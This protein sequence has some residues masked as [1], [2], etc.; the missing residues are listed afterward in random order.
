[1]GENAA[2]NK[3]QSMA[4]K[5]QGIFCSTRLERKKVL[6]IP[7]RR[8][9]GIMDTL[10]IEPRALHE[11]DVIP[12][13]HVPY[14]NASNCMLFRWALRAHSTQG[15]A[16]KDHGDFLMGAA[17]P[18]NAG[19][20]GCIVAMDRPEPCS[21]E[22]WRLLRACSFEKRVRAHWL[23]SPAVAETCARYDAIASPNGPTRA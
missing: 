2:A 8:A 17:S 23:P 4:G 12:L 7:C 9:P 10:G 11:A 14:E 3:T 1:M 16:P 15:C 22:A 5:L 6:Q 18:P 20:L 19:D 21:S 13:H